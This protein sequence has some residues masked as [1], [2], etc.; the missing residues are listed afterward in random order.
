MCDERKKSDRLQL[1]HTPI[2]SEFDRLVAIESGENTHAGLTSSW[3][4]FFQ[5]LSIE[6]GLTISLYIKRCSAVMLL[7]DTE[8]H[9]LWPK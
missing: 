5:L 1:V 6:F 4:Y 8:P 2:N 9:F 7:W 3:E